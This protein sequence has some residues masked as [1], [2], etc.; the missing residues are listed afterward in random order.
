MADK[1]PVPAFRAIAENE[2]TF[3]SRGDQSGT[4]IRER[5]LWDEANVDPTGAWYIE[6]GQGMGDTLVTAE[7][8]GA[9][10]LS[11]RGTFLA[12]SNDGG[13]VRH[14][15]AGIEDPP[16]LLRNEY[17]VIPVD[18]ARRD[19]TYQ[20]ALAYVGYRTGPAQ[21]EIDRFRVAGERA[22]RPSAP[23]PS[24]DFEQ[25]VPSDWRR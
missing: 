22:F 21:A 17:A 15:T 19:V 11:D 18:P 13:L 23:S 12:V 14:V 25:Y 2:E 6:T 9:Y 20:L 10:T 1:A 7:Q 24:P 4:H 16:P 3:I 8:S 5:R